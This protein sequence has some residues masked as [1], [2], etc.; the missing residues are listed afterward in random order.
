MTTNYDLAD[1]CKKLH[2]PLVG[3]Y[4]KD[5]IPSKA[6]RK[7]GC[8][9]INMQDSTDS[10]G[11]QLDGTHWIAFIIF[12]KQASFFDPFGFVPP[13]SVQTFLQEFRPYSY[14]TKDIQNINSGI[15]GYY[16]LYWCWFMTH[17]NLD[18]SLHQRMVKF[19]ELFDSN[20]VKNREIL[21]KLLI[22]IK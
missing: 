20:P 10:K 21:N 13:K 17:C 3:V 12:K 9:I 18:K 15:C 1:A 16:V 8:Y 2:I 6:V 4:S 5:K 7:E 11:K 19:T 14:L 22:K